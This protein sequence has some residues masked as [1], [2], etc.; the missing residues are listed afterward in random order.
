[1]AKFP[2]HLVLDR[3]RSAYNV[4]S[5]FRTAECAGLS[6][7]ITTAY[8]P[9]ADHPKVKKTALGAEELVG[10]E[11][12]EDLASAIE[13]LQDRGVAVYSLEISPAAKSIWEVELPKV[14]TAFIFGHEVDG[15]ELEVTHKF[16]VPEIYI[17]Q[18]G[19][20]E[21]LNVANAM[22]VASYEVV[23]RWAAL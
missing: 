15:V 10:S 13:A 3:V 7:V 4:G 18:F 22:A 5:A 12:F 1:M 21:S 6:S 20:K 16:N 19:E 8:S 14:E 9:R 17:P 2:L 11:H 23:R